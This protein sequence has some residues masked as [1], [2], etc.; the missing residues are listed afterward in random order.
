MFDQEGFLLNLDDWSPAMAEQIA[1][2]ENITL[3]E[4]HWQIIELAREYHHTFDISPEMRPFVKWVGE[5][6]GP[7]KGRSI[8]LLSLFPDSPAK[9]AS[10]I[11]GL[12]KPANCL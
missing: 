6:L 1:A 8:Y 7:E 9:L 12:P 2:G 3:T 10:K 11:A 5:K 4:A